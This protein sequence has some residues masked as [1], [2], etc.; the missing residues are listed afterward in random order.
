MG[1]MLMFCHRYV[2]PIAMNSV[3]ESVVRLGGGRENVDTSN[4][5]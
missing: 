4:L 5:F 3:N 1:L 2:D